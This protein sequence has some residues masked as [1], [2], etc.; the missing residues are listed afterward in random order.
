MANIGFNQAFGFSQSCGFGNG[1]SYSSQTVPTSGLLL[2]L[3]AGNP[4]SYT[5]SG[6]TW[7][8]LAV[9]PAVNNASLLNSPTFSSNNGGFLNFAKASSQSATVSGTGLVPSSAYTKAVWFNLT[10]TVS[11]HNLVSSDTGGHFM[12]FSGTSKMYCGHSNWV[13]Y[14]QYPSTTNFSSGTWYLAVLTYT[15]SDG[16]KLYVNGEL[17]S[18]YTA[19]KLAHTGDGSVN[20]GRFSVG[21]FLNGNIAQVLTYNRAIASNEVTSIYNATRSRYGL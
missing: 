7:Y 9:S 15:T 16:M 8:D 17:D 5:G 14:T 21:N 2:W 10:D 6:N 18:T 19:N 4:A 12:Y 20:L 3:D 1:F 13:G 11:D